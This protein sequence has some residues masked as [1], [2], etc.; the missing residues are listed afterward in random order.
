MADQVAA[1]QA[2]SSPQWVGPF[3]V[4]R[5]VVDPVS[6]NVGLM[7]DPNPSGPTVLVRVR[8]VTPPDRRGLFGW[9]DLLVDL[10]WGW[11]YREED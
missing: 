11:E 8:P 10:G 4:A 2:S 5:S 6:G 7:I 1:G 9:D 3:R